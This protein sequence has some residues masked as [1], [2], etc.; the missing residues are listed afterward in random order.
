MTAHPEPIVRPLQGEFQNLSAYVTSSDARS[1]TPIQ[2]ADPVPAAV[3]P[4]PGLWRLF[5][6]MRAASRLPLQDPDRH[7][8]AARPRQ[9]TAGPPR[10][11]GGRHE[12][13]GAA[14]GAA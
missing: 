7:E 11:E 8:P 14:G 2:W 6:V 12:L 1:H 3:G 13:L 10:R 5:F 4:G 9:S